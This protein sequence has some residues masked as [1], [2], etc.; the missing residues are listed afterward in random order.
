M[1]RKYA[2]W[3]AYFWNLKF[4]IWVFCVLGVFRD[5]RVSFP[6]IYSIVIGFQRFSRLYIAQCEEQ[7]LQSHFP[8]AL[9]LTFLYRIYPA[10]PI[11][12]VVINISINIISPTFIFR[13]LKYLSYTLQRTQTMQEQVDIV[14]KKQPF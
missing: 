6:Y 1:Q 14:L 11:R 4:W 8:A 7:E 5:F 10:V 2:K 3:L 12:A 9:S 13:I